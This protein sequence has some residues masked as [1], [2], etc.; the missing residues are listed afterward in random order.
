VKIVTCGASIEELAEKSL[1][2]IVEKERHKF[3]DALHK[4]GASAME[5]N[6]AQKMTIL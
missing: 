6:N 3:P 5:K 2:V 1:H 4:F